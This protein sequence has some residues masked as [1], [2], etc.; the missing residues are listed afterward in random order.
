MTSGLGTRAVRGSLWL[1]AVNLVSKGG[2][3]LVTLVLAALL[4]EGQLGVVALAVSLVNLGQ[5][6]QSVGVYDVIGRTG[7][8]PRRMAGTVLTMSVGVGLLLAVVLVVA[9]E[10]ITASLGAPDAAGL[11]RLAALGLPFAAA[12]GVQMGLMHRELDFRRRLLPDGGSAILG[13]AVTVVLA[14]IGIGPASLVIGLV[15]TAVAQPVLG[16]LA[17]GGVRPRWDTAAAGEALR[18]SAVVGPAAVVGA[19]LV[20]LDYFTI[21]HLLGP[22]A[23]GLYS[24]A[25][26]LAWVP[27]IMVA[28]VLGA[29][30]FPV[31]TRLSREGSPLADA[32]TRFTRAV[33]VLTGG[34]YLAL[35]VLADHVVLLGT[36]WADAAGP[37]ILLTGYGLGI[38]LLQIWYQAVKATGHAR[39]YLALE[40]IHLLIL[41]AGLVF[42]ARLGIGA[43]AAVQ[44]AAAW[45]VVP[46]TWR[47]LAGLGVA[48]PPAELAGISWRVLGACA[49]GAVPAVLLDH[50]GL[51]GAAGSLAGVLGEGTVLVTGYAVATLVLQRGE[52]AA[53]RGDAR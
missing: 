35:A 52:L 45:L 14:T 7:R 32:V 30:A 36:R 19:L 6:V 29:V 28:V 25:Y 27:Y 13:A 51:F 11:V 53:V 18:W 5:V 9:A 48:P 24:L 20:N 26:R 47:V 17:G 10:P 15:S 31:F 41:A 44:F 37:L 3:M 16:A 33:L 39:R 43:V 50:A 8:D 46:I 38:C 40:T 4:T 1:G 21:G 49:A 22:D 23:L 2:Q 34:L 12:G 42:S